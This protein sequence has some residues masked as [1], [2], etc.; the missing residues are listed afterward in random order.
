MLDI[1]RCFDF[2]IFW[3]YCIYVDI[4]GDITFDQFRMRSV[5]LFALFLA[6]AGVAVEGRCTLVIN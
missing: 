3:H 4:V 1:I 6:V 2:S 5:V